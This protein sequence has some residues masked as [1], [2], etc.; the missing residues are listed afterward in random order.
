MRKTK[1]VCY[2]RMEQKPEQ[3]RTTDDGVR[4]IEAYLLTRKN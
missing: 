3:K 2:E 4:I 1:T